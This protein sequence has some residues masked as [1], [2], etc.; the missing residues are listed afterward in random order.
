MRQPN[1]NGGLSAHL[2][3][4]VP[5]LRDVLVLV[6]LALLATGTAMIYPPA[7]FILVGAVLL[8]LGLFGVPKWGS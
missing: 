2:G 7:A 8:A 3:R 6:G 4:F 1:T 5:E